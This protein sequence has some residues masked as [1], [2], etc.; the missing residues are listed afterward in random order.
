MPEDDTPVTEDGD[1]DTTSS[2][3]TRWKFIGTIIA[4]LVVAPFTQLN[5]K[6]FIGGSTITT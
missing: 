3:M 4:G 6:T 5:R 2:T 1:T